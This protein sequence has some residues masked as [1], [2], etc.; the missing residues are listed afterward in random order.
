MKSSLISLVTIVLLAAG[1]VGAADPVTTGM[2]ATL[3]IKGGL[4]EDL[5]AGS[6]WLSTRFWTR[7]PP[8]LASLLRKE[9]WLGWGC[10]RN[11]IGHPGDRRES[12]SAVL[13]RRKTLYHGKNTRCLVRWYRRSQRKLFVEGQESPSLTS[14]W[15]VIVLAWT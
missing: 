5:Q 3:S 15:G 13:Y 10:S 14:R 11:G 4:G 2:I 12:R 1:S 6:T 7:Q 9:L 8:G